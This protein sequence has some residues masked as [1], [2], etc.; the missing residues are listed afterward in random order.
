MKKK[1]IEIFER[2]LVAQER[3]AI[4]L[5]FD[6]GFVLYDRIGAEPTKLMKRIGPVMDALK[7]KLGIVKAEQW[8]RVCHY[9][10]YRL[11]ETDRQLILE[12]KL[13]QHELTRLVTTTEKKRQEALRNLALGK[14]F[15][16]PVK[17]YTRRDKS[18]KP[19][20]DK[21]DTDDI[22]IPIPFDT[23][24]IREYCDYIDE[25][26]RNVCRAWKI[27]NEKCSNMRFIYDDFVW[28]TIQQ[29]IEEHDLSKVS[30]EEFIQYQR[31]FYPIGEKDDS[32]FDAAWKHH[33]EHNKHHWQSW[34][35]KV[36]FHP[37]EAECHCVCMICDWMAMGM[38]FND[39]AEEY[40]TKNKD[41]ITLP[42][43]AVTFINEIFDR[44]RTEPTQQGQQA[45]K[46]GRP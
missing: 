45:G 25:H 41:K 23:E 38:K 40:Y 6:V 46:D 26:V 22:V 44:I 15:D 4:Q 29:M 27:L 37:Y 10:A 13:K 24:K 36:F 8:W 34:A 1:L 28:G 39:T 11:T 7:K 3:H 5:K 21:T 43:W 20:K 35:D 32:G 17:I 2:Y 33:L 9:T 18:V 42:D 30:Q 19:G 14:K 31:N 16:V 12:K